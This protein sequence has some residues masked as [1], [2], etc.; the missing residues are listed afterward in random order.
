MWNSNCDDDDG[1][2][3]AAFTQDELDAGVQHIMRTGRA[4]AGRS[5]YLSEEQEVESQEKPAFV[6]SAGS[7][8]HFANYAEAQ[9]WAK[10]NPGNAFSRKADGCGFEARVRTVTSTTHAS[11]PA[12]TSRFQPIS[13]QQHLDEFIRFME[14]LKV[15]SPHAHAIWTKSAGNS[16]TYTVHPFSNATFTA[17]IE[18]LSC[19]KRA[20][21]REMLA[22]HLQ[23]GKK[24]LTDLQAEMRRDRRMKP[25]HYGEELSQKVNELNERALVVLDEYIGRMDRAG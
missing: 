19:E 24:D 10:A 6:Q 20:H 12:S 9:A 21:L 2:P 8:L 16:R 17:E 14:D 1:L 25:G 7:V 18:R 4:D 15:L 5:L 23:R 3:D 13:L 22:V 11:R